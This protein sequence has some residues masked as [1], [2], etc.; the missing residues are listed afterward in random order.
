MKRVAVKTIGCK[1]NFAD[2][3]MLVST[4]AKLGFLIVPFGEEADVVI[5]NSCVVTHRAEAD[6]RKALARGKRA[7]PGARTI[8][9]GCGARGGSGEPLIQGADMVLSIE[10]QSSEETVTALLGSSDLQ[11]AGPEPVSWE[12]GER[13]RIFVKIQNG[14]DN[15]CSYCIVPTV[16]GAGV[17][18]CHEDVLEEIAACEAQGYREAVLTGTH[19]GT[20][21][22]DRAGS[23]DLSTLVDLAIA[24]TRF[25]RLRLSSI[26]VGELNEGLLEMLE[27]ERRLCNH[28]HIPLQS[29]DDRILSRMRRWYKTEDYSNIIEKIKSRTEDICIGTDIITGFPGESDESFDKTYRFFSRLPIDYAHVFPYSKREGTEAATLIDRIVPDAKRKRTE[30]LLIESRKKK[31]KF[32]DSFIG[33]TLEVV[34][35]KTYPQEGYSQ[36]TSDNYIKVVWKEKGHNGRDFA[37]VRV[38]GRNGDKAFGTDRRGRD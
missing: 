7:S 33:R 2:T 23:P 37:H 5:V 1:T 35:E 21:G 26:E 10:K 15:R 19:I 36:G 30:R 14:C 17:S 18:R 32:I 20:Y 22:S 12:Q 25:I 34:R 16:R 13:S 27:K 8:L 28:V 11:Q 29:G 31:R 24:R 3:R 4:L 38:K 9:T 6:S